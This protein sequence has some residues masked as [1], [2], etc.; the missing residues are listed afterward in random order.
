MTDTWHNIDAICTSSTV[1]GVEAEQPIPESLIG[2]YEETHIA[3]Y[4]RGA[5]FL[6]KAGDDSQPVEIKS[7]PMPPAAREYYVEVT[8]RS[9]N[10]TRSRLEKTGRINGVL[11]RQTWKIPSGAFLNGPVYLPDMAITLGTD[12]FKGTMLNPASKTY[13]ETLAYNLT[14]E[15]G[16]VMCYQP[17]QIAANDPSG[18]CKALYA[19]VM[20]EIVSVKVS[21]YLAQDAS[22]TISLVRRKGP[23]R[24]DVVDVQRTSFAHLKRMENQLWEVGP[25]K[26]TPHR[27][28]LEDILHHQTIEL[29]PDVILRSDHALFLARTEASWAARVGALTDTTKRLTEDIDTHKATEAAHK[30]KIALL[31]KQIHEL[32][33]PENSK[34][35]DELRLLERRTA[36]L[37]A[38]TDAEAARQ[39][40]I[41]D[42]LKAAR[43]SQKW[44][45]EER[46]RAA[47]LGLAQQKKRSE[48]QK[49]IAGLLVALLGSIKYWPQISGMFKSLI[50]VL[51]PAAA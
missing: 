41:E 1:K 40:P 38:Q 6:L 2:W 48:Q 8:H 42:A 11:E 34:H 33:L 14:E 16:K 17:I 35:A 15:L 30:R 12:S 51:K 19:I 45:H 4:T 37:K 23:S 20:G 13:R 22:D 9:C 29:A 27:Q 32:E 47:E 31:E 10:G 21:N 24:Q 39:K 43:D 49:W 3:N 50:R 5:L 46:L 36:E 28:V 26:I 7:T 44:H 18:H 25:Y